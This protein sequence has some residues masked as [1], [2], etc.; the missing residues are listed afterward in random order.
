MSQVKPFVTLIRYTENPEETIALAAKLCY[1]D[2]DIVDLKHS[3]ES[4][5]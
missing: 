3:T 4:K 2:A 1:S 5:D